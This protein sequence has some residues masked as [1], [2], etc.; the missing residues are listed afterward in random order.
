M[1]NNP[2]MFID[3]DGK[4]IIIPDVKQRATILKLINDKSANVYAINDKT[5]ELYLKTKVDKPAVGHSKYYSER[6]EKAIADDEKIGVQIGQTYTDKDGKVKNV[7]ADAGGGVTQLGTIPGSPK[8]EKIQMITI[9][10][11]ENKNLKDVEGKPLRDEASDILLHEFVGHAIPKIVGT[12]TG[13]AVENENKARKE[14]KDGWKER[15]AEP[16]HKE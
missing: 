12:D 10:G 6:L 8:N 3:P 9:S 15:K 1:G 4:K 2:I 16:D 13:N 5:G 11:N 14:Q 7:D